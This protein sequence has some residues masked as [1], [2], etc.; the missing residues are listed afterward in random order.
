MCLCKSGKKQGHL[1]T[2]RTLEGTAG[3]CE[4]KKKEEDPCGLP[5]ARRHHVGYPCIKG[6]GSI[7]VL[8]KLKKQQHCAFIQQL[9]V[10]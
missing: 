1:L 7:T 4:D 5:G 9:I 3:T 2:D 6:L 10:E 8:K